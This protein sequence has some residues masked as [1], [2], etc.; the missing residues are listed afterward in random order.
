MDLRSLTREDVIRFADDRMKAG[1][2][3]RTV[4]TA[5]SLLRR[6]CTLHLEAGLIDENPAL[7]SGKV[8]ARVA[9]RFEHTARDID[10][11][12]H[13]EASGLLDEA[14][15]RE[16]SI[17]APLLCALH[18]GMRRGEVLGLVW[19][20]VS[21]DR[22]RLRRALVRGHMTTTKS[23]KTRE[24]PISFALRETLDQL[25]DD[26][27]PWAE[28]GHVFLSPFGMRWDE[29]NFA[30]AFNRL[31]TKAHKA[32]NVRPLH[33]HCARHTFAIESA[34]MLDCSTRAI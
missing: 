6:V 19:E 11:W 9:R 33:F 2:A 26:L 13:D 28:P 7:G 18:T 3:P 22:I 27:S 12:T 30:R 1:L 32:R 14:K 10:A 15:E 16:P 23:G 21:N 17:Y 34:E 25:R 4:E 5:L 8:V 29:R 31:R 24:I 20:D